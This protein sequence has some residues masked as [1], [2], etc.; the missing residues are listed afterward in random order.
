MPR[1]CLVGFVPDMC[2][3]LVFNFASQ[4][5]RRLRRC[6]D[7]ALNLLTPVTAAR[8]KHK[9]TSLTPPLPRPFACNPVSPPSRTGRDPTQ[10]PAGSA[11]TS[12]KPEFSGRTPVGLSEGV[13]TDRNHCGRGCCLAI[14]TLR[15]GAGRCSI[16]GAQT[17][18]VRGGGGRGRGRRRGWC[19]VQP[20]P[21]RVEQLCSL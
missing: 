14:A 18:N 3:S 4:P 5:R 2:L 11:A 10:A 9:A 17:I 19:R 13:T 15:A 6:G 21:R 8:A 16:G 20:R 12:A 1:S 7:H